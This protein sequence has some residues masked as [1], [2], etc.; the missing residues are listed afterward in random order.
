MYFRIAILYI[1]YQHF[2]K[3][4]RQYT[5]SEALPN[6]LCITVDGFCSLLWCLWRR[7]TKGRWTVAQ[8][9]SKL[10]VWGDRPSM[11]PVSA[12]G[13]KQLKSFSECVILYCTTCLILYQHIPFEGLKNKQSWGEHVGL[14]L[15]KRSSFSR[16]PFAQN[17]LPTPEIIIW[18]Y[19]MNNF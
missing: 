18:I 4:G 16:D 15:G 11:H 8:V 7:Q 9:S 12:W 3:T 17:E 14:A 10:S 2:I 19:S 6:M 5:F 1:P 13:I